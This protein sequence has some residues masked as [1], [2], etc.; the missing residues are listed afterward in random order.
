[1]TALPR[2]RYMLA[3]ACVAAVV[4]AGSVWAKSYPPQ[5]SVSSQTTRIDVTALLSR[6]DVA[7]LPVLEVEQPF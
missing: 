1:M 5:A 7:G 3:V 6:V 2:Q 4:V